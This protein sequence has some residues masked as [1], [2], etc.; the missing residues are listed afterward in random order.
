MT[1][2]PPSGC[3]GDEIGRQPLREGPDLRVETHTEPLEDEHEGDRRG[4]D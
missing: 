2:I 4:H 3:G 1:G